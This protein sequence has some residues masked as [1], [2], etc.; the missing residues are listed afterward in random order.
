MIQ[1]N[2][3]NSALLN[4]LLISNKLI[5]INSKI[6]HFV[7]PIPKNLNNILEFNP[8][9]I[10][11][12]SL[13]HTVHVLN[14]RLKENPVFF[15]LI[16]NKTFDLSFIEDLENK[17]LIDVEEIKLYKDNYYKSI[18]MITHLL[19][20]KVEGLDFGKKFWDADEFKV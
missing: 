19:S 20:N 9:K 13:K 17:E 12:N 1:T 7:W 11:N 3:E 2:I 16:K 18:D 4:G 14:K 15:S 6:F 10:L 8:N 5:E